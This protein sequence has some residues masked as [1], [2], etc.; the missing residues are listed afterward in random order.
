MWKTFFTAFSESSMWTKPFEQTYILVCAPSLY[1]RSLT[2]TRWHREARQ[3]RLIRA[4]VF[5]LDVTLDDVCVYIAQA[6][7]DVVWGDVCTLLCAHREK[8]HVGVVSVL[9]GGWFMSANILSHS[10][11]ILGCVRLTW[12][13]ILCFR[14]VASECVWEYSFWTAHIVCNCYVYAPVL[15]SDL[16]ANFSQLFVFLNKQFQHRCIKLVSIPYLF[17]CHWR[18][19]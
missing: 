7:L 5:T 9:G 11:Q 17:Y 14:F 16:S 12:C 13:G 15:L 19:Q 4:Y 10:F 1:A 2:I 18:L 6:S 8:K 3:P